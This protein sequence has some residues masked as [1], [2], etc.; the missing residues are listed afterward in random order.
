MKVRQLSGFSI[1]SLV[2]IVVFSTLLWFDVF[3]TGT[4]NSSF[5][6]YQSWVFPAICIFAMFLG[7]LPGLF[8]PDRNETPKAAA[9]VVQ[10]TQVAAVCGAM[11]LFTLFFETLGYVLSACLS[12]LLLC[13]VGGT[14]RPLVV[15]SVAV[16][17]PGFLYLL[18]V[19]VLGMDLP[20]GVWVRWIS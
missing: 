10:V 16:L 12:M 1:I 4:S 2:L 8:K 13:F 11:V 6:R 5:I 3:A 18:I 17:I 15:G 7:V 19:F 20:A 9:G 14:G